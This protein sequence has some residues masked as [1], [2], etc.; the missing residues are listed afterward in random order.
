VPV[1]QENKPM[2][3]ILEALKKAQAE[4]QLGAVPTIHAP[5]TPAL[6]RSRNPL[7]WLAGAA[8]LALV[9]VLLWRQP[10]R[11]VPEPASVPAPLQV[12]VA[13]PLPQA[14]PEIQANLVPKVNQ[15]SKVS[16]VPKVSPAPEV[17]PAPKAVARATRAEPDAIA[18]APAPVQR[19]A[20]AEDAVVTLRELPEPIQRQI[21][22]L[23]IGGYI[24][25]KNPEDRLLLVDKA[26]RREGDE[27]APG[28]TL[29]KLRP[30]A[31]VFNFNGYRYRV[32][33]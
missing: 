12:P 20:A 28:L 19:A 18:S 11:V 15:V 6:A 2:S 5:A 27:L 8:L 3:Y 31:A 23:A 33:Y 22:A 26:L 24:Y 4:R 9:L 30:T 25:S 21:P 14:A 32:P 17:S 7:L 29:E 1:W 13:V 16:P 10:W